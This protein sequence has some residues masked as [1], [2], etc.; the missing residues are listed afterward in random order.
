MRAALRTRQYVKHTRGYGKTILR[1][2]SARAWRDVCCPRC[3]AVPGLSPTSSASG[4][5][6]RTSG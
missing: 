2:R 1:R 6:T 3:D 4:T 5:R